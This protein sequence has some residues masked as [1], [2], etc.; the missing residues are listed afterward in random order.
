MKIPCRLPSEVS[1]GMTILYYDTACGSL[2]RR[3]AEPENQFIK[4]GRLNIFG[5]AIILSYILKL[6]IRGESLPPGKHRRKH[7]SQCISQRRLHRYRLR[8][9]HPPGI[10]VYKFRRRCM[11]LKCDMPYIPPSFNFP[12]ILTRSG[13]LSRFERI[14]LFSGFIL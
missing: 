9:S 4:K 13:L 12:E 14:F 8:L 11:N 1:Q 10:P 6:F 7:R 5:T 2:N 3:G